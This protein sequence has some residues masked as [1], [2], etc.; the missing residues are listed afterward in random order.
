[1]EE[2][3]SNP[4][5]NP[6]KNDLNN[7]SFRDLFYKYIRFLPLFIL[8][9]AVTLMGAFLYLRYTIPVYSAS[10]T[11]VIK[12][13]QAAGNRGDKVEELFGN[14]RAQ[15]IQSEIEMLKSRPLM[16][17][18]VER[19]NLQFSYYAIGKII[20]KNKYNQG[21]FLVRARRIADSSSTFSFKVRN[22]NSNEFRI[23]ENPTPIR[24][25]QEFT[26][27]NGIFVLEKN[28]NM[29]GSFEYK[30]TWQP[31]VT[32]AGTFA[33]ALQVFPKTPGTGI[34]NISMKTPNPQ[35]GSD[36]I[37]KLMEEYS[38][39]SV[40]QKVLSSDQILHFIGERLVDIGSKLDSVQRMYLD[41]QTRYNLIDADVQS[42]NYFSIISESDKSVNEQNLK[43]GVAGMLDDYLSDK[44]NE[45]NKVVVPSSLG[46]DDPTLNDL[47]SL[48][49]KAQIDRKLLVDG[50]VPVGNPAVKELDGQVEKIRVSIR[51]NLR[52]IKAA[53]GD[54]LQGVK[55]RGS[56]S[57]EQLRAMPVKI[58]EL[59]EIKR[60]VETYQG[61]FKLFTEKKEETAISKASTIPNS[62]IIDRSY[63]NLQPVSP[64]RRSIQALAVLLGLAIP[65][66]FIF[67]SEVLNDKVTTRF[68]IEKITEAPILGEIGHSYSDETLVVSKTTRSMVAEQ[69]RIIRSNL[70]Y[71]LGK[72]EKAVIITTSS[73]SGEGK[74]YV[75]TN[76]GAVLAL[77]GKKTIILEFD[78]RKPKVLTGLGISR[79]GGITNFLVGKT[80]N[81][82][83]LI[84]EVPEH[85]NLFVL[86]CGPVPPNP[87]ELLLDPRLDEL[88]DWLKK[89]F[90]IVIIDTA[91]VGMVSDA[92]TLSKFADCTLYLVRQS[93]TFKKQIAL[94]DEFYVAQKL[95][96][97][98]I[99]INDVKLKPGYGYYGYGRYGYGYGYGYGSYYE[100]ESA[101]DN[102]LDRLFAGLE[103]RRLLGLKKKKRKK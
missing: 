14:N 26:N 54:A 38:A 27:R 31:T 6:N 95:P 93:H 70:Q 20:T 77:A 9:V 51:E 39:Y 85:E 25:G 74:S 79:G 84:R 97:V 4:H 92:M 15:N 78:I 41:Y 64:N 16:Q 61:L 35:L 65:A 47:V 59:A 72:K 22:L 103:I 7:L 42:G 96:K 17:R 45:F 83:E 63:P 80:N 69:F 89:N 71:V 58:K 29:P 98:S 5:F 52:N 43:L 36:I 40:E 12:N 50:N 90:D 68:D 3:K 33:S 24:Y 87:A 62:E 99:I 32:A 57:E 81:I 19:L 30:V 2:T 37:N 1:M 100:E 94:I 82:Q 91:P 10:G 8:S 76:M 48:Y 28:M 102:F 21:P 34:L 60:Q 53:T 56:L 101:P 18:V 67:I 88:F 46:L 66:L 49:N 55:R 73:F 13:D 75:S 44:K 23:D 86:G 11:M